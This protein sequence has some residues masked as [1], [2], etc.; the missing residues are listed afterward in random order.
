MYLYAVCVNRT[1]NIYIYYTKYTFCHKVN[2]RNPIKYP[3]CVCIYLEIVSNGVNSRMSILYVVCV[4]EIALI[5][6]SRSHT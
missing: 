6:I 4:S 3:M 1:L 5:T 2:A